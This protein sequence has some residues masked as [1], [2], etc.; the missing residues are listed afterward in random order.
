[1]RLCM[2][3]SDLAIGSPIAGMC[4]QTMMLNR[5]KLSVIRLQSNFDDWTV[6]AHSAEIIRPEDFRIDRG[7]RLEARRLSMFAEIDSSLSQQKS[8]PVPDSF[9]YRFLVYTTIPYAFHLG[10]S[11]TTKAF[12]SHV[13]YACWSSQS[14]SMPSHSSMSKFHI[15]R[16]S[17]KRGSRVP[18][19][20]YQANH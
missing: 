19:L 6:N 3:V 12:L 16:A 7:I 4:L 1:M 2:W 5:Y 15:I 9:Q 18:R 20:L 13:T 11:F 10:R 14:G 17:T 8:I